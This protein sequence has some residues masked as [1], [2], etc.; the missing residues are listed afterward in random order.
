[1]QA[2]EIIEVMMGYDYKLNSDRIRIAHREAARAIE[3]LQKYK[4][5]ESKL[6]ELNP[7]TNIA[8][9]IQYFYETIFAGE[10]HDGFCILTN[11][12]SKAWDEYQSIG[13][14]E[15]CRSA[16]EKMKQREVID[17]VKH[18][19]GVTGGYVGSCPNCHYHI[20]IYRENSHCDKCGQAVHL[21][22]ESF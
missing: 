21:K 12:D 1:M 17:A 13:S 2:E 16:V 6:Q 20:L 22:K 10:S 7:K 4:E 8:G 5:I 15:E 19:A 14:V 3:E 9:L 11:E 18:A